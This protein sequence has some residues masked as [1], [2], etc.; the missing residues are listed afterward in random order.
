MVNSR[1]KEKQARK[2]QEKQERS[3]E[4]ISR[5]H[6]DT[7]QKSEDPQIDDID[8]NNPDL[9]FDNARKEEENEEVYKMINIYLQLPNETTN[10]LVRNFEAK[11]LDVS[12]PI[13]I[14]NDPEPDNGV[15]QESPEQAN[16]TNSMIKAPQEQ[17]KN[18]N[19]ISDRTDSKLSGILRERTPPLK[20]KSQDSD[21][22]LDNAADFVGQKQP[23]INIERSDTVRV[24]D[25]TP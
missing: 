17:L 12:K 1:R 7:E 23:E 14:Q 15:Q 10:E 9:L 19:T 6:E 3:S 22:I 16:A 24:S 4:N 18:Q 8:R 13:Q 11:F 20:Q 25:P 2:A 5:S 21:Q